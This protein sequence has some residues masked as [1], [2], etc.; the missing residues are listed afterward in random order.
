MEAFGPYNRCIQLGRMKK[1]NQ[2]IRI[3]P[4]TILV[5]CQYDPNAHKY[6]TIEPKESDL[7]GTYVF[8]KQTADYEITEFRDSINKQ[9]VNPKIIINLDGTYEV[10]NLPVFESHDTPHNAYYV[11]LI[12]EKGNWKIST[13]GSIGDGSGNIKNHWGIYMPELPRELR[14]VGLMNNEAPY[15]IIFGF[16]D[17][18][19]GLAMMFKKE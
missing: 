6:T 1:L 10:T 2:I 18:D 8:D 15:G 9:I 7:I 12:S 14:N 16:G 19:A 4:L 5:S 11:G 13:V 17:P 3:L